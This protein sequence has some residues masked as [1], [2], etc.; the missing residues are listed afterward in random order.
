MNFSAQVMLERESNRDVVRYI[1]ANGFL[2]ELKKYRPQLTRQELK[3]LRGQAL[4]GDINGAMLGLHKI[5]ERR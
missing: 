3:T 1:N 5:L 4:S 2:N